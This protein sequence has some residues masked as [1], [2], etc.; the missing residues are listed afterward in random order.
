VV[1]YE[2]EISNPTNYTSQNP[3]D[4]GYTGLW[5]HSCRVLSGG[6]EYITSPI[7]L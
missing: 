2:D 7:I 1:E 3:F 6:L 5:A 4:F